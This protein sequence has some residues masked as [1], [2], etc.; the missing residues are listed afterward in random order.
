M[1]NSRNQ[2]I[3]GIILEPEQDTVE[4]SAVS[5]QTPEDVEEVGAGNTD[6][7]APVFTRYQWPD[8][9]SWRLMREECVELAGRENAST[10]RCS[11]FLIKS[12]KLDSLG[13]LQ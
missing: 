8:N 11:S 5:N 1:N 4:P 2:N 13:P 6:T 3:K 10:F 9:P 7:E 12:T